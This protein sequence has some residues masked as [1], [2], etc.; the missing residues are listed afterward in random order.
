MNRNA[1]IDQI[2]ARAQSSKTEVE[3][4]I[5]AALALIADTLANGETVDLR[6]FGSFQVSAKKE[7]QGRNPKTGESLTIPAKKVALFKPSK[8]LAQRVNGTS[9][10][11][12]ASAPEED[13]PVAQLSEGSA[14]VHGDKINT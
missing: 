11:D 1:F 3:H 12:Q 8:E 6:G 5:D 14:K 7:R 13:G 10:S 9:A 4:I 2:A